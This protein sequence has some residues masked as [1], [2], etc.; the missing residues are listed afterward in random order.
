MVGVVVG[1]V[2]RRSTSRTAAG[3]SPTRDPVVPGRQTLAV[4]V[5]SWPGSLG[6]ILAIIG[7]V[8]LR[9]GAGAVGGLIGGADRSAPLL[10]ALTAI[11]SARRSGAAIGVAVG[12]I[13]WLALIGLR[14]MRAGGIDG[15]AL[16]A[17]FYPSQTIE[18]TK[19][20]I[21]WVREQTPLGRKS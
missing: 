20:T 10:G 14:V 18:T 19:E 21:E 17:R 15:E 7:V 4:A 2:L 1:F 9:A 3:R 5:G 11:A 12:L 13:A 16:K 6:I 8:A